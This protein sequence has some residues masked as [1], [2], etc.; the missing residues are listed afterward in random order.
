MTPAVD[1]GPSGGSCGTQERRQEMQLRQE[2]GREIRAAVL[3]KML[4]ILTMLKEEA[5]S[6]YMREEG[7]A[8]ARVEG[9]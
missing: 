4:K 5:V 7:G 3:S 2:R 8:F 1:S 9:C 6:R